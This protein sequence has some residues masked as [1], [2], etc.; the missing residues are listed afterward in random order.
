MLPLGSSLATAAALVVAAVVVLPR[1]AGFKA[2]GFAIPKFFRE[3]LTTACS[4]SY[5]FY[6]S[7]T[8]FMFRRKAAT[9]NH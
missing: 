8:T 4:T 7:S 6:S 5:L 3:N 1:P 2:K 9:S